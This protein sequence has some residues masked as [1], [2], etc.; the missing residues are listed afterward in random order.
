MASPVEVTVSTLPAA[1]WSVKKVYETVARDGG[2]IK[3]DIRIQLITRNPPTHNQKPPRPGRCAAPL[4]F[5]SGIPSTRQGLGRLG[6]SP[7]RPRN[8]SQ[9]RGGLSLALSGGPPGDE[10]AG[11]RGA[12]TR[13]ASI[14]PSAGAGALLD[15]L[16]V[17]LH[18][19][20]AGARREFP[21]HGRRVSDTVWHRTPDTGRGA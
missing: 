4:G 21:V 7:V 20:A 11:A 2:P 8:L 1:S 6:S 17:I 13:P 15:G 18:R 12:G 5:R 9:R 3:T 10:A 14:R 19:P 16:D